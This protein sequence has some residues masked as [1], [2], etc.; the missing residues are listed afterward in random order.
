MSISGM[1]ISG[2]SISGMSVGVYKW[3]VCSGVY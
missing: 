1:S 2:M 3:N